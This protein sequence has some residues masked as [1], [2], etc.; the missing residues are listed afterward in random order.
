MV[1]TSQQD[2]RSSRQAAQDAANAAAAAAQQKTITQAQITAQNFRVP[3]GFQ[4]DEKGIN[5]FPGGSTDPVENLKEQYR[6]SGVVF[7]QQGNVLYNPADLGAAREQAVS[8]ARGTPTFIDSGSP[9]EAYKKSVAEYGIE[10]KQLD[11]KTNELTRLRSEQSQARAAVEKQKAAA[12]QEINRIDQQLSNYKPTFT[13]RASVGLLGGY[14]KDPDPQDIVDLRTRKDNLLQTISNLDTSGKTLDRELKNIGTA[15]TNVGR[16]RENALRGTV[17]SG[18]N[19]VANPLQNPL[20]TPGAKPQRSTRGLVGGDRANS[21][22]SQQLAYQKS[23]NQTSEDVQSPFNNFVEVGSIKVRSPIQYSPL[24]GSTITARQLKDIKSGQRSEFDVLGMPTTIQS[25]KILGDIVPSSTA[26]LSIPGIQTASAQVAGKPQAPKAPIPPRQLSQAEVNNLSDADYQKYVQSINDYNSKY[27]QYSRQFADYTGQVKQYNISLSSSNE[28]QRISQ[29]RNIVKD[30]N[31]AGHREVNIITKNGIKT[32]PIS[33]ASK[34]AIKAGSTLQAIG[35]SS[36]NVGSGIIAGNLSNYPESLAIFPERKTEVGPKT[37]PLLNASLQIEKATGIN[38]LPRPLVN[39]ID[40]R[41]ELSKPIEER[42]TKPY[43]GF[44]AV[45]AQ[46]IGKSGAP[47]YNLA[48]G[49][50]DVSRQIGATIQGKNIIGEEKSGALGLQQIKSEYV[51]PMPR[52]PLDDLLQGKPVNLLSSKEQPYLAGELAL[53]L[54]TLGTG[55][56]VDVLL[57]TGRGKISTVRNQRELQK[58]IDVLQGPKVIDARSLSPVESSVGPTGKLDI[59]KSNLENIIP[60][61]ELVQS[62]AKVKPISGRN[63]IFE[64]ESTNPNANKNIFAQKVGK[65]KYNVISVEEALQVRPPSQIGIRGI[66]GTQEQSRFKL[67]PVASERFM[68]STTPELEKAVGTTSVQPTARVKTFALADLVKTPKESGRYLFGE[69]TGAAI[70]PALPIQDIL[71]GDVRSFGTTGSKVLGQTPA[72]DIIKTKR[73]SSLQRSIS[74][75]IGPKPQVF[76]VYTKPS[77]VKIKGTKIKLGPRIKETFASDLLRVSRE[78]PFTDL[79]KFQGSRKVGRFT[80][81]KKETRPPPVSVDFGRIG[82][83]GTGRAKQLVESKQASREFIKTEIPKPREDAFGTLNKFFPYAGQGFAEE[84]QQQ[85]TL[86]PASIREKRPYG[87]ETTFNFGNLSG[88]GVT[89]KSSK[90]QRNALARIINVKPDIGSIKINVETPKQKTPQLQR[91]RLGVASIPIVI[92]TPRTNTI[93]L[94]K[95]KTKPLQIEVPKTIV[96]EVPIPKIPQPEF[97]L[98]TRL[99]G[100][101]GFRFPI[102]GGGGTGGLGRTPKRSRTRFVASEV[103]PLRAGVLVPDD[104]TELVSYS[105]R[106]FKQIDINLGRAR[107]KKG[108]SGGIDSEPFK[109]FGP[110]L[111]FQKNLN[112]KI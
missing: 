92:T 54:V 57:K 61:S 6:S 101:G 30:L 9:S 25:Q 4:V 69:T 34:E 62:R 81:G 13:Q 91:P 55:K 85:S 59:V 26:F 20:N 27:D 65:G 12:I 60:K 66:L 108:A 46:D 21:A 106:V 75:H 86:E 84:I 16:Q 97:P 70:E 44:G 37:P 48:A 8:I 109:G 15:L 35:P 78:N 105:P 88:L 93:P 72:I 5:I 80:K 39:I 103:D 95:Q 14:N 2:T 56:V 1:N 10:A 18:K 107:R 76:D 110:G 68:S 58:Q 79:T 94:E 43:L 53:G 89:P 73:S 24:A 82:A 63:D 112:I 17:Q 28:K 83:S 71:I 38:I 104:V 41:L 22:I 3:S 52:T 33:Q 49:V 32:V 77:I 47:F 102:F 51:T 74:K 90:D 100:G 98:P 87:F 42:S 67:K 50:Y 111:L 96:P 64:I 36:I 19:D 45:S 23:I 11:A 40:E 7:N 31:D 29:V 99:R